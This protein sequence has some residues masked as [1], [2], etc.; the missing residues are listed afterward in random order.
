MTWI[1]PRSWF[2]IFVLAGGCS[3]YVDRTTGDPDAAPPPLDG[4]PAPPV[5]AMVGGATV[6]TPCSS[7]SECAGGY[8]GWVV[9]SDFRVFGAVCTAGCRADAP[10]CGEGTC[11]VPGDIVGYC[12]PTCTPATG[13]AAGLA[14]DAEG[15]CTPSTCAAEPPAGGS[16]GCCFDEADCGSGMRCYRAACGAAQPGTCFPSPSSGQCWTDADCAPPIRQTVQRC[17]GAVVF[18][19][20]C[21]DPVSAVGQPGQ[22]V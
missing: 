18:D 1:V 2:V 21:T 5:D 17:E 6:G 9:G 8:C 3:L 20:A 16:P 11:F 22:C 4:P 15:R 14:C 19:F 13:C 12:V 7:H 10:A